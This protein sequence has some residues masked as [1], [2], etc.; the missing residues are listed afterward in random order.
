MAG[1]FKAYDIR[2]LYE[3]D[4]TE[5]MAYKI[6]RAFVTYLGCK[7]VLVGKDTRLSTPSLSESL[8]KGITDQGADVL[9]IGLSTTDMFYYAEN[10]YGYESGIMVT[11]SHNPGKYNGFK[12]IRE[13]AAP[14]GAGSGIEEIEKIFHENNFKDPEKKGTVSYVENTVDK[15]VEFVH[16]Y[17]DMKSIKPLRVVMDAGNGMAG[18]VA[19]KMFANTPIEVIPL[20]FELDGSFPNHE[21][22]PLLEENRQDLIKKVK[23]TKADFGIGFDGDSDRCFVV[24]NNGNFIDGDFLT[25]ILSVSVLEKNPNGIVFYDVRCSRYTKDMIEKHGGRPF[26]WMVGHA[27][28]KP[29]MKELGA[30]FGGEVSGH[31]YFFFEDYHADNSYLP[32]FLLAEM[33]SKQNKTLSELMAEKENYFISG[34]INSTVENPDQIIKEIEEKYGNKGEIVRID[35]LSIVSDKWWLNM[36]KSNT[37]PLLRLNCEADTKENMEKLRDALLAIIRK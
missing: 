34:E 26:M 16:S 22:N 33:I 2:G 14:I 27:L 20:F 17:T 5:E 36:R 7:R 11:A 19:P 21:A 10:L 15:F 29:K 35:G 18:F 37:E 24:D 3:K 28:S 9:D 25:G 32:V 13:K 4:L 31:Y 30:V 23:E 8:I 1:V 12:L 6:G